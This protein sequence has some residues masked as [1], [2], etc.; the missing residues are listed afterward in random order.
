MRNGLIL[1]FSLIISTHAANWP[2]W[3]G[4]SFNGSSPDKDLPSQWSQTENVA[5]SVPLPGPS[6]ATPVIWDNHVFVSST[7]SENKTLL[8][9]CFDRQSGKTNWQHK[10]SDGVRRDRM[11]TF[12][13]PSPATDGERAIFFFSNGEL[14]AYDFAGKQQWSRNIQQDYGTF[15]FNWTFSSTPILFGGKLY[16]EVLQRDV[17]VNGRGRTNGPNDSYLLALDP[18]TGKT[19]WQQVRP[20]EAVEESR[21][22][23]STPFPYTWEGRTDLLI[24]GGDCL[25]GHD[26][27]TGRELWRWGTWNS[28][29]INH[30]RQVVSPVAGE[31]V[32]LACAPKGAPI[33][34]LKAGGSG[35][36]P[37]NAIAW[38]SDQKGAVSSDVPTPLFYEG[39]FF[40]LND[41]RRKLSR[42]EPR[43]GRVKWTIDTPGRT[44]YEASPTGADGKVYLMNFS[45]EVSVVNAED[46]K[47]LH[48]IP[49]G[50]EGDDMTRSTIAI[51][52]G[53][54]FIRTN[55]R[56]FCIG[57]K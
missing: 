47:V 1:L 5:W 30:W 18:A 7:D 11:S 44:K 25:T 14:I 55:S 9:M 32:I 24:V 15:A 17:P 46:G 6:A 23:Y 45:G 57:R 54:L 34:A 51:A 21:E 12:S 48:T 33:Y 16:L 49:M 8:A 43:T 50:E 53:Q 4:P 3:R 40:V 36:L 29:R 56:L 26:P 42:V 35:N 13:A 27:A 37:E 41:L 38:K 52:E 31:G 28:R 20:S 2:Q 19:V 39:D 10:V 22:A